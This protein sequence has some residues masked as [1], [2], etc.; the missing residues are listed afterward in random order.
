MRITINCTSKNLYH[1]HRSSFDGGME[2]GSSTLCYFISLKRPSVTVNQPQEHIA[3]EVHH[4]DWNNEHSCKQ[5]NIGVEGNI[6]QYA[7][8]ASVPVR[9]R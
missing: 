7:R 4:A 8:G 6:A 9:D 1:D 5:E 3:S 2:L